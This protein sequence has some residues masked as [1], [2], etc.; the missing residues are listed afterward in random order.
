MTLVLTRPK[1]GEELERRLTKEGRQGIP[2]FLQT[3]MIHRKEAGQ[4]LEV[5]LEFP[6]DQLIHHWD[7]RTGALDA[8]IGIL[9]EIY[10]KNGTLVT[11]F[12]DLL[13]PPYWPA[14]LSGVPYVF[15]QGNAGDEP[16]P[17]RKF[18]QA[19]LPRRY[20]T[21]VDLRPGK[22]DLHVVLSDGVKFGGAEASFT[23]QSEDKKPLALSSVFLCTRYRDAHVASVERT[24]ANFVPQYVPLVSKNVEFVPAGDTSF[25]PNEKLFAYFQIIDPRIATGPAQQIEAHL[26]IV[27]TRSAAVVKDFPSVDASTYEHP[28]QPVPSRRITPAYSSAGGRF[29]VE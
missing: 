19:W 4:R 29:A 15:F 5:V 20:E 24:A 10:T 11:R 12:S 14:I 18:D 13:W 7:L 23:V 25:A 26:R 22:Y 9:G 28:C 17:L 8:R 3:G 6:W 2:L 16:H 21:Q 1:T 27:D